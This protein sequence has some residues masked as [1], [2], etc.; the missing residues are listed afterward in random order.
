MFGLGKKWIGV[1][2]ETCADT[3]G[4]SP[5]AATQ[6]SRVRPDGARVAMALPMDVVFFEKMELP[7]MDWKVA[8]GLLPG[9][10]DLKIP[11]PIEK[12]L[13]YTV[14][15]RANRSFSSLP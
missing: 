3:R 6:L 9:K 11:V 15:A 7:G 12:C 5:C 13:G 8:E 1:D 14:A 2:A 4:A 10:F